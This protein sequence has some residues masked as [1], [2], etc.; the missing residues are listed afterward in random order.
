MRQLYTFIAISFLLVHVAS[1]QQL[2]NSSH[3]GA[4][5]AAWNPAFTANGTDMIADGFFRTQ[6][7]GFKGAPV[8]GF[9]SVQYPFLDYNMSGGILLHFDRTGPVSKIGGQINYAYH[10]KQAL[11][12]YGQLSLGIS[13]SFNQYTYDGS[14]EIY[15]DENDVLLF[16]NRNSSVFPSMGAGFFYTSN[17]RTFS[18]NAFFVGLAIQQ[19][20]TTKV[21][22]SDF[23]QVRQKH[24]HFNLGGRIVQY[25][26]Y[27]EPMLTANL[28]AP[29][30]LDVMYSLKYEREDLFWAGLGYSSTGMAAM[31][32][33]V[34]LDR[35]GSRY[36]Q[37][38]LGALATYGL[39]SSLART[40]P[41][42]ELYIA[43]HFDI[44]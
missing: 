38:R 11:T 15:N 32:G 1:A 8:T 27:F 13:G 29:D 19:L 31:Q 5:R 25:D 34:I 14:N 40:G 3:I 16:R 28:V 26:S 42:F 20:Y 36:A 33:G 2:A 10:L 37:L 35:F 44:D 39:G 17:T 23:D 6:W 30:I 4:T 7:L 9:A 18:D 21:L 41:G 12:R 22:I 24:I 43:Y